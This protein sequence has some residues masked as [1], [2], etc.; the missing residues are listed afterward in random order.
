MPIDFAAIAARFADLAFQ[1]RLG[2]TAGRMIQ[3]A[4]DKRL[5]AVRA[6]EVGSR[7]L[8]TL[9]FED[10]ALA[11]RVV[12][13]I[14]EGGV[15]VTSR[16]AELANA[17]KQSVIAGWERW[18]RAANDVPAFLE[19]T[20]RL[21]AAAD[22]SLARYAAPTPD[23]FDPRGRTLFDLVGV[24]G[25]FFTTMK[26][27]NAPG[28][29]LDRLGIA[30]LAILRPDQPA[31][32]SPDVGASLS[33]STPG[34]SNPEPSDER[35]A[36]VLAGAVMFVALPRLVSVLL[37]ATDIRAHLL[38]LDQL[39]R[40]ERAVRGAIAWTYETVFAAL[41]ALGLRLLQLVRGIQVV[42]AAFARG[43]MAFVVGFGTGFAGAIRD[44][45]YQLAGFLKAIVGLMDFV[46]EVLEVLGLDRWVRSDIPIAP[47]APPLDFQSNFPEFG[48]TLF[49]EDVRRRVGEIVAATDEGMRSVLEAGFRRAADGLQNAA[50]QF[51]RLADTAGDTGSLSPRLPADADV[52]ADNLFPTEPVPA[53][54]DPI[55]QALESWMA[56]GG[57]RV[58]AAVMDGYARQ[59][60]QRWHAR[61]TEEPAGGP[62]PGRAAPTSPHILRRHA[63]PGRVQVPRLLVRVVGSPDDDVLDAV[64]TEFAGAVRGAYR[65]GAQRFRVNAGGE[66][67]TR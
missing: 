12:T 18:L 17:P 26:R 42:V 37:A 7:D 11:V 48:K 58:L 22:E 54:R 51:S 46:V 56:D 60:A 47:E 6:A 40:V 9:R 23:A 50:G 49:G 16:I 24:A 3:P 1:D 53:R 41:R 20:D 45:V 52:V 32:P 38:I 8:P 63:A 27:A 35:D 65:Q 55:A 13:A 4:L 14:G 43:A 2:T 5:I 39:E 15:T 44:F 36:L 30:V 29:D 59:V 64:A 10:G 33:A 62:Q 19:A 28:G 67:W 34:P 61:Y 66:A 31:A 25:A 57:I 21:L